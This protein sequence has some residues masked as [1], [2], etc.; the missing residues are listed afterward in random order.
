MNLKIRGSTAVD[1][2]RTPSLIQQRKKNMAA[3]E[4]PAKKTLEPT[5][6][7]EYAKTLTAFEKDDKVY[8]EKSNTF[9]EKGGT[10]HTAMVNNKECVPETINT[11]ILGDL[12][13]ANGT[14]MSYHRFLREG[15]SLKVR[16][17]LVLVYF[18]SKPHLQQQKPKK[19]R[20]PLSPPTQRGQH[21]AKKKVCFVFYPWCFRVTNFFI[22]GGARGFGV[23]ERDLGGSSQRDGAADDRRLEQRVRSKRGGGGR[24]PPLLGCRD[25]GARDRGSRGARDRGLRRR[26]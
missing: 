18:L 11:Q 24:S 16:F 17:F 8:N 19:E 26:A 4:T 10:V 5:I 15:G 3:I 20:D 23:Q 2:E 13:S 7:R 22:V 25:R 14:P 21:W 9:V 6:Y 1:P 12:V